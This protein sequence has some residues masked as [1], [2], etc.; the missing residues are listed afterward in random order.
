MAASERLEMAL[1]ASS[2]A[3]HP[4]LRSVKSLARR[5]V[6]ALAA[7]AP[8][9]SRQIITRHLLCRRSVLLEARCMFAA[10]NQPAMRV[11]QAPTGAGRRW[12]QCRKPACS[13]NTVKMRG[14]GLR[15]P[16]YAC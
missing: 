9:Q 7:L 4:M 3:V 16:V 11:R 2:A 12:Q 10:S 1:P 5:T 6:R 14:P 8:F 13:Y 15:H